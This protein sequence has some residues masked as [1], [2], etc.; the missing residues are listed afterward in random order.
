[1]PEEFMGRLRDDANQDQAKV[2]HIPTVKLVYLKG[3]NRVVET[4]R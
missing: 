4:L 3:Q 1:M 2:R